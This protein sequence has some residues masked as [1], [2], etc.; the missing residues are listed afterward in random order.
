M[1]RTCRRDGMKTDGHSTCCF[2][3]FA[4]VFLDKWRST[5]LRTAYVAKRD[6]DMLSNSAMT[7]SALLDS[8]S[9]IRDLL[10]GT[11]AISI[12]VLAIAWLGFVTLQGRLMWRDGARIVLGCFILFGSSAIASAFVE[13]GTFHRSQVIDVPRGTNGPDVPLPAHPP[14]FDP[15]AGASV[16]NQ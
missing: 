8:V 4:D 10:T 13:L 3:I 6:P 1:R 7:N 2:T 14:V 16:P 11:L 12:A 5:D 9:W 15:Y